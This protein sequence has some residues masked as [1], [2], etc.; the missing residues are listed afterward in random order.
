[1]KKLLVA[2]CFVLIYFAARADQNED[3]IKAC[4]TGNLAEVQSLVAKGADVNFNNG[5]GTPLTYSLMYGDVIKFLVEKGANVGANNNAALVTAC[6]YGSPEVIKALLDGGADPNKPLVTDISKPIQKMVDDE[7]AK[8]KGA[9][10]NMIKAWEAMVE[11]MKTTPVTSYAITNLVTQTNCLECMQLM[12]DK[13]AKFDIKNSITGGNLL[14]EFAF[15][16]RAK[17]VRAEY[18]KTVM[19]PALEKYMT[20][21]EWYKNP[22]VNKMA[23]PD[24]IAKFLVSKGVDINAVNTLSN[25]PLMDA[26]TVPASVVQSEVVIALLNNGASVKIESILYG[27]PMLI[28]AGL[29]NIEIMDALL[30]HGANINDEFSI[31]DK[32]TGQQLKGVTLVMWACS[33]DHL[34]ALKYLI[35]KKAD[36]N[37]EAHGRSL[38]RKTN[39][40]T[41]VEGKNAMFFAIETGNIELVKTLLEA[42]SG[43]TKALLIQ[44]MKQEHDIGMLTITKCFD[45]GAFIPS[46]YAKTLGFEEIQKL[47]KS[48]LI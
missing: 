43:W 45:V 7:K 11:K 29:G 32:T 46:K 30:T 12:A 13:G 48:K 26:L 3:L 36:L 22:D 40:V 37:E 34:D 21:P 20:I 42:K 1:M 19:A 4:M 9:N 35:S 2:L 47:L 25:A 23:S 24:E 8:G 38:N 44:Q 28:A 14:H 15:S 33:N 39:C 27:K 5:T 18:L 31:D 17:K 6:T 41:K 16:G 10:K